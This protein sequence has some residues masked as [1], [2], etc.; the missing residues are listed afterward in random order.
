LAYRY[1][2]DDEVWRKTG[3]EVID[4]TATQ[5]ESTI[6]RPGY[7]CYYKLIRENAT[8]GVLEEDTIFPY[9]IKDYY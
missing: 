9:H 7:D 4:L 2:S 3:K 1:Y 6:Y 8:G 5:I